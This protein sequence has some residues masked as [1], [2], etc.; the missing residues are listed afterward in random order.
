MTCNKPQNQGLCHSAEPTD[1]YSYLPTSKS[2]YML[3]LGGYILP[4]KTNNLTYSQATK[5]TLKQASV[6]RT[7]S[8]MRS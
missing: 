3:E 4:K 7:S 6:V 2:S 5:A 8:I 1:R